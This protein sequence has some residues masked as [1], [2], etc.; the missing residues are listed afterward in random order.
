MLLERHLEV[1]DRLLIAS[2]QAKILYKSGPPVHLKCVYLLLFECRVLILRVGLIP[3]C[4]HRLPLCF[5]VFAKK[6]FLFFNHNRPCF[7][8]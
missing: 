7:T 2:S 4:T 6:E 1:R 3:L 8:I 5:A